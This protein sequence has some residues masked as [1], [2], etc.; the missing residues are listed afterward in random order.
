MDPLRA[1][2]LDKVAA[3][4]CDLSSGQAD[5]LANEL[6]SVVTPRRVRHIGGLPAPKAVAELCDLWTRVPGVNGRLLG[7]ALRCSAR[8]VKRTSAYE[9]VELLCTGPGTDSIRRTKQALLEV[10]RSARTSLWVVSYVVGLGADDIV[11]ALEERASAGVSVK[12]LYDHRTKSGPDGLLRLA[13]VAPN[14]QVYLWPDEHRQ[15]QPGHYANLHAKC[16]VADGR[17]AFVSS[18]NLTGWAMEHNLE[19]GYM[20]TGGPTPRALHRY[21]DGLVE[22]KVATLVQSQAV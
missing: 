16:A 10:V 18:A 19:V 17:Q 15:F 8:A 5:A 1:Q 14:C 2:L 20:V 9:K 22:S 4:A 7:D 3:L 11:E 6:E 12:L 13:A 21:L